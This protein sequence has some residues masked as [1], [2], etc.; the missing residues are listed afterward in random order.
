MSEQIG[1]TRNTILNQLQQSYHGKLEQYRPII[2]GAC[3]SDPE[4]LAH[5]VAWDFTHGQIKDAKIALP[6]ITLASREF[7]DELVR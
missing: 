2:G 3:S 6:V 7:P 5:L 4:F 1:I